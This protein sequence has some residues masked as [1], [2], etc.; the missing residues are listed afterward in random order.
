MWVPGIATLLNVPAALLAYSLSS[1]YGAVAALSVSVWFGVMY[2]GPSFASMQ[3]LVGI[4]ERALGSALLL[5][6]VNLIGL[7]LGQTL[8]GVVS[9]LM[10]N[11][12][13]AAGMAAEVAKAQGLRWALG[14]MVCVNLWSFLHYMI[15]ARTLVHDSIPDNDPAPS[16]RA[17]SDDALRGGAR[18]KG[19]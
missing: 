1:K 9:D 15:A 12:F 3:R 2:L 18:T 10:N 13:L 7:G 6:V 4:R 16:E 8:V 19:G 11:R 14:I 17:L 5:F